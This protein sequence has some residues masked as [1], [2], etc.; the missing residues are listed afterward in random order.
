MDAVYL[1]RDCG[2]DSELRHSLRSLA[3]LGQVDRV[4]VSGTHPDW[5]AGDVVRVAPSVHPPGK[6]LDAWAN[7]VAAV[8]DPRVSD[9]FVLMN[10]D[11][12]VLRPVDDLPVLA[13]CTW[14]EWRPTISRGLMRRRATA[15]ALAL[16]DVDPVAAYEGH[17]PLLIDKRIMRQ[18]IPAVDAQKQAVAPVWVRT[19]YGNAAHGGAGRLA[20]DAKIYSHKLVPGDDD[21][22]VSTSD[23]AWS[24]GRVGEWLRARFPDPCRY[25]RR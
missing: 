10:D 23:P 25:E 15:D 17:R 18:V 11:F 3:N 2:D 13:R 4:V 12:F 8:E 19:V 20:G 24:T 21:D 14:P 22:F 6:F 16:L 1:F 5:L 7:L 9:E